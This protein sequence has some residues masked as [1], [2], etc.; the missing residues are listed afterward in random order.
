MCVYIYI[1][2][3]VYRLLELQV[4]LCINLQK[5]ISLGHGS[6]TRDPSGY[7]VRPAATFSNYIYIYIHIYIYIYIH[8]IKISQ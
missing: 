7:M 4:C 3:Y 2:T 6:P 5:K 1:S 8:T